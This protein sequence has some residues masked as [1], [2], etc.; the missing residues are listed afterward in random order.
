MSEHSSD[1]NNIVTKYGLGG[2]WQQFALW[3]ISGAVGQPASAPYDGG[4]DTYRY[5][6]VV[7]IKNYN[8]KATART[9]TVTVPVGAKNNKVI[10]AFP[11]S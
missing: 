10:T 6:A 7:Q 11:R 5:S 4:N 8:S 1:W 9:Y 3:A 2:T